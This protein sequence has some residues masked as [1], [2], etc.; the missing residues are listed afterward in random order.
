MNKQVRQTDLFVRL[1]LLCMAVVIAG[2]GTTGP[3]KPRSAAPSGQVDTA[4]RTTATDLQTLAR[5]PDPVVKKEPK[6]RG[7]NRTVYTVL[8]KR[9]Q[10]MESAT[11]YRQRGTASWY[12]MK[13][14][15]RPTANGERFDIYKLT[16]AHRH[17]PIPTY[18][19]VTNLSNRRTTIVRVN[20]RGPFHED[21]IIDLSYA[22]AVKLG[23]HNAGTAKVRV[24]VID[25]R[26]KES[27]MLQA[28]AFSSLAAADDM[29]AQL[30]AITPVPAFV[31]R[32]T[33]D[34]L[35]RVR[36]GPIEG[37]AAVEQLRQLLVDQRVGSPLV[38]EH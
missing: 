9:Y 15:G 28:G 13:F 17:L 14:H 3:S 12:G 35:F 24:E 5:L 32:T 31:V 37:K 18:V 22:A 20:D 25:P 8:G 10:V 38:L 33:T 36:L 2:C 16:A 23:F 19:R 4:P 34:A 11:G 7:G 30:A 1:G 27:F 26:P 21:R 6:S 29:K